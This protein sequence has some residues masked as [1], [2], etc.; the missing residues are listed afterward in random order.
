MDGRYQNILDDCLTELSVIQSW[1]DS[2][3][4]D[5]KIRFLVAY[6]VIKSCG[7]IETVLKQM[8]YDQLIAG[9]ANDE[10]QNHFTKHILEASFNPSC[11]Q[12]TRSL[13]S[14]NSQKNTVFENLIKGAQQKGDL[15]SLVELRN[16]FAHG[17]SINSSIEI[18]IR[19]YNSGIWIL[20]QLNAALF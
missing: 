16:S 8:L 3:K 4:L 11:G 15:G 12:I 5:T 9:G 17:N 14:I 19:Y 13:C 18:V 2:N 20:Q 7:T 10:A 1:I 6:A